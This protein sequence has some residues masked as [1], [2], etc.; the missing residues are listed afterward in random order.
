M[1]TLL[2]RLFTESNGRCRFCDGKMWT[3][4]I[5]SIE[6]ARARL[7]DSSRIL[8]RARAWI[9]RVPVKDRRPGFGFLIACRWCLNRWPAG[10]LIT[11]VAEHRTMMQALVKS[12]NHPVGCP[13]K[14]DDEAEAA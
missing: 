9:H 13:A 12:G 2:Q 14:K 7:G 4:A 8:R 6:Q 3:P 10:R 11:S 5:E 1:S